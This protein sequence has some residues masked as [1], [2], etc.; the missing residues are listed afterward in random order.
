MQSCSMSL[1]GC[2]E[3]CDGHVTQADAAMKSENVPRLQAMHALVPL[4]ALYAPF[5]HA[6]HTGEASPVN[7]ALQRQKDMPGSESESR[8]Q[9]M[10]LVCPVMF[11]N[12]PASHCVHA[13]DPFPGL[14]VPTPHAVQF[15]PSGPEWPGMQR[16]SINLLAPSWESVSG[17]QEAQTVP[18]RPG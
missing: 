9:L 18:A 12:F 7:P 8:E 10:Q 2:D 3:V 11:W 16:Q 4:T 15:P 14:Y 13:T 5:S 1:P 6:S 17:G